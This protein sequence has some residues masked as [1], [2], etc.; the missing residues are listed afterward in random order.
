MTNPEKGS[1]EQN[2]LWRILKFAFSLGAL[3]IGADVLG[4]GK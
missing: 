4:K 2:P 1:K 3:A